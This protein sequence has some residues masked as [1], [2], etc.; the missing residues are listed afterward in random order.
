MLLADIEVL[1]IGA[2]RPETDDA[3]RLFVEAVTRSPATT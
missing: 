2:D 1:L 3:R